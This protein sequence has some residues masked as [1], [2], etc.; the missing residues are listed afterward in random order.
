MPL[1]DQAAEEPLMQQT[2][3]G[4]LCALATSMQAESRR[5]HQRF[6]PLIQSS[7]DPSSESSFL[8]LV[9]D[10]LE[11]LSI[12]LTQTS[13]DDISIEI[14]SLVQFV[15]PLYDLGAPL[16]KLLEITEL[17]I[18]LIPAE[19]L[20]NVSVLLSPLV[21]LLRNSKHEGRGP[22]TYVVEL[23]IR[24]A[25]N[26]G[27]LQAVSDLAQALLSSK[28]ISLT[29][30]AL[31]R[32]YTAHQNTGPR[33]A[34][35]SIDGVEETD[36]LNPLA[37]LAVAS[38][39]LFISAL[40]ASEDHNE[41]TE[42]TKSHN[43]VLPWMLTEWFSHMDSIGHP[44]HK[45]LNCLALTSILGTG[46]PWILDHLQSLITVVSILDQECMYWIAR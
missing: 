16:K 32:A 27:G 9:E 5:Y 43:Q 11:L 18:F 35:H 23:L 42:V 33:N 41:K 46:Q 40:D 15:F 26:I 22:T 3:L 14:L 34:Y 38:P 31:H 2:I 20:S 30:S 25:D 29:I 21:S 28:W 24:H 4:L 37:R 44:V 12:V 36:F 39:S 1:W 10:G 17:Y 13:S 45:K 7:I 8:H 6:I 19:I